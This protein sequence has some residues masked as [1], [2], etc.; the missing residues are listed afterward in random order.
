L[1]GVSH[2]VPSGLIEVPDELVPG[3]TMSVDWLTV[4]HAGSFVHVTARS[5][6]SEYTL[7]V[8][9]RTLGSGLEGGRSVG[10]A[11]SLDAPAKPGAVD[12]V[13]ERA[14]SMLWRLM[15][16]VDIEMTQR[17]SVERPRPSSRGQGLRA[18]STSGSCY[19]HSHW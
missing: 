9:H 13:H 3:A 14:L 11:E 7:S 18:R 1:A 17:E 15:I 16:G 4:F 6:S 8:G 12:D 10:D 5:R 2:L 19:E